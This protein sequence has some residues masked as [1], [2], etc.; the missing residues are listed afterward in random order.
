[1]LEQFRKASS[2]LGLKLFFHVL[3]IIEQLNSI[4]INRQLR[5]KMMVMSH[6][7]ET[8]RTIKITDNPNAI[9]SVERK[10]HE[11]MIKYQQEH[12]MK[13]N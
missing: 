11:C 12:K 6:R 1:M 8:L 10:N 4:K 7:P 9:A 5:S 2:V 13:H 3:S